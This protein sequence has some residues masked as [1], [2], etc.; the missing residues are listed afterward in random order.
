MQFSLRLLLLAVSL[1]AVAPLF[2][3]MPFYTDNA[4]V[5]D[6]GTLHFEIYSELDD[7]Q[8]ALHPDVRQNTINFKVNYGLPR[9]LELDFDVPYLAIDRASGYRNTSGNG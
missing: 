5:T 6:R 3:Q 4:D 7:L 2:A 9:R 1:L 8:S